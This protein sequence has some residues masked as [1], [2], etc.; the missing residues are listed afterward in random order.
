MECDELVIWYIVLYTP[1]RISARRERVWCR[2][3]VWRKDTRLLD[4]CWKRPKK[5]SFSGRTDTYAGCNASSS[6]SRD[7]FWPRR[8]RRTIS[9]PQYSF[10]ST[11][12]GASSRCQC[13]AVTLVDGCSWY[14]KPAYSQPVTVLPCSITQVN[15]GTRPAATSRKNGDDHGSIPVQL[16]VRR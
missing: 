10:R 2:N 14:Y 1:Y 16:S 6:N 15:T 12:E 4:G 9:R 3:C 11:I 8:Q 5:H 7:Y 13:Q